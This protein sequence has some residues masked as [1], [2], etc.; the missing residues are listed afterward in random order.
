MHAINLL[1]QQHQDVRELFEKFDRAADVSDKD[2]FFQELA[3]TLA[4]HMTIEERLFYPAAYTAMRTE[5]MLGD[6]LS[7][8]LAIKQCLA[9]LL[10]MAVEDEEFDAKMKVLQERIDAHVE[11]EE[12]EIFKETRK[13][14]GAEPLKLLGTKMKAL[15]DEEMAGTPSDALTQKGG[16]SGFSA[17]R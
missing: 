7:E 17:S 15:F 9:E 2:A 4:A 14:L 8:H 1:K 13:V 10:D 3:D 11:E 5:A 12:G 16:E 6:A